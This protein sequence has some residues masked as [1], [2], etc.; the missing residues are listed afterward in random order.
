MA[1][2]GL[3]DSIREN[4]GDFFGEF[5][6]TQACE[7]CMKGNISKTAKFFCEDCNEYLCVSCKNPHMVYKP[8]KHNI[9]GFR[10]NVEMN[11]MD[12]CL[13]HNKK[14]KFY[15]QDH[16]KL[17]CNTCAILHRKCG[18][19]DEIDSVT[20]ERLADIDDLKPLLLKL[21]SEVDSILA[22]CKQSDDQLN[23]SV[24]N[25]SKDLDSMKIRIIKLF[26]DAQINVLSEANDFRSEQINRRH[27]V[28]KKVKED[29]NQIL[30]MCPA[31]VEH[32]TPQQNYIILKRIGEKNTIIQ[33]EQVTPYL[34]FSCLGQ[35]S[36]LLEIGKDLIK[37]QNQTGISSI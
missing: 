19:L 35:L 22:D 26:E 27:A 30:Q 10:D 25:V 12:R 5:S 11:G 14:I 20:E 8:G 4:A 16:S 9:F 32:G 7:P 28:C 34:S 37:I 13:E 18:Q 29:L 23:K 17:C 6:V 15:C 3:R 24:S 21:E 2:P 33:A 36:P 1:T 31:V